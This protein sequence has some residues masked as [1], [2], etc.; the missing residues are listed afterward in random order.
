VT[1]TRDNLLLAPDPNPLGPF[2]RWLGFASVLVLGA[3]ML[4][5]FLGIF[6]A[7]FGAV[8]ALVS[9]LAGMRWLD[10]QPRLRAVS[11]RDFVLLLLAGAATFAAARAILMTPD[12]YPIYWAGLGLLLLDAVVFVR[13]RARG[14]CICATV[15][16]VF[17]VG[18][19]LSVRTPALIRAVETSSPRH[20]RLFLWFGGDANLRRQ[21]DPLLVIALR[22]GDSKTVRVLLDH[23][24]DPNSQTSELMARTPALSEAV[25]M[26]RT[27]LVELLL[28]RGAAPNLRNNWG[29]TALGRAARAGQ[30]GAARLL[31]SRGANPN[32]ADRYGQ[33]PIDSARKAQ[34]A[35]VERV[36]AP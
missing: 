23:G 30:A 32:L 29:E 17:F 15:F 18:A 25:A 3:S 22:A 5:G 24:A 36:L 1:D 21:H 10:R 8:A 33:R 11:P 35:D 13:S 31:L 2:Y 6:L 14:V 27:D 12:L 34:H 20:A 16:L 19:V 28:D 7:P 4:L 26:G 9:L